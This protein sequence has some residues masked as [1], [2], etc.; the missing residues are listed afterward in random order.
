MPT[1]FNSVWSETLGRVGPKIRR[2][3]GRFMAIKKMKFKNGFALID[4]EAVE[5]ARSNSKKATVSWSKETKSLPKWAGK[6]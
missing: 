4:E 6:L 5:K 2:M 1:V 3:E